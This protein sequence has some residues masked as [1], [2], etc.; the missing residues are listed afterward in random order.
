[1]GLGL[2]AVLAAAALVAAVCLAACGSSSDST[3][4]TTSADA[5]SASV[6]GDKTPPTSAGSTE[7]APSGSPSASPAAGEPER[8]A[9]R[10]RVRRERAVYE[11]A[12]YGSPSHSSAPFAKY[13]GKGKTKLHLAEF[14]G[15]AGDDERAAA[16]TAI[17]AYLRAERE[18]EW[19]VACTYLAA[20]VKAQIGELTRAGAEGTST[21]A[22]RSCGEGL[23]E[24]V[25]M[26]T[27]QGP[28]AVIDAPQG[29]SSLRTKDGAGFALFH[30]SDGEDHWIAVRLEPSGWKVISTVPQPFL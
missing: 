15:E 13:S 5:P 27:A 8:T 23:R 29:I 14:G 24:Y 12:R 22:A 20:S 25:T 4:T 17:L 21:D 9:E 1:M 28:D 30:G 16:Q 11:K 18:S 7:K 26:F 2:R 6:A 10:R 3:S 19:E